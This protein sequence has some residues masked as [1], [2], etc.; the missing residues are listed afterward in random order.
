MALLQRGTCPFRVKVDNAR[1]AG[2]AAAVIFNEGQADRTDVPAG[3]LGGPGVELPVVAAS[4]EAGRRLAEAGPGQRL[5]V[6]TDTESSGTPTSNVL[7]ELPGADPG[8]VVM[9]GGHPTA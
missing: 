5:R 9:A 8:R 4:F 3:T 2:A 7:V 6:R 1:R